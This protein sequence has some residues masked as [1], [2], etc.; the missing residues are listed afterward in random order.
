MEIAIITLAV[1]VFSLL[2]ER[3]VFAKTM[4]EQLNKYMMAHLSKDVNEYMAVTA[5]DKIKKTEFKQP[6]EV[7]LDQASDEEWD[8]HIKNQIT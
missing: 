3:Y 7:E 8:K 4:T 5:V 2:I 1:V 6:D